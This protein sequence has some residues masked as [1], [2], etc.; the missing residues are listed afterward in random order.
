MKILICFLFFI[1]GFIL[2]FLMT[3]Y[4]IFDKS[5]FWDWGGDDWGDGW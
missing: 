3:I 2:L 5:K 1:N 4:I